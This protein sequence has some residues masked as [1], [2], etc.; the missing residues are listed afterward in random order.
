VKFQGAQR[1]CV[2]CAHRDRCLLT[3]H[4]TKVRQVSFFQGKKD[5][6][7]YTDRMKRKIDSPE[8]RIQ[9]GQRFATVEPVFGNVRY[10][11]GLD[12]FT[13]RG[14]NKVDAQWKLFCLV[15]NIEKLAHHGYAQ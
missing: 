7:S 12:R 14:R 15:H 8:G 1:D 5:G 2:P 6:E 10:N 13:L 9:Y 3:P 4:K 11:K